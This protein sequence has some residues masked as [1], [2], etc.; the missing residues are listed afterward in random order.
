MSGASSA[1]SWAERDLRRGDLG[2][3]ADFAF[4]RNRY[5]PSIVVDRLCERGFLARTGRGRFRMTVKG[6]CAVLSR[7]TV[8]RAERTKTLDA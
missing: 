2:I 7:Q 6:W 1:R 3:L 4:F 8:A 5:P